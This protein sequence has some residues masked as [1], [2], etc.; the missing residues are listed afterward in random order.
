MALTM[1][2][3][4][5]T[6]VAVAILATAI[7]ARAAE[8]HFAGRTESIQ[9]ERACPGGM[10]VTLRVTPDGEVLGGAVSLIAMRDGEL[11]PESLVPVS[12]DGFRATLDRDGALHATFHVGRHA[13][14]VDLD[15]KLLNDRFVG[16]ISRANCRSRLVLERTPAS[17]R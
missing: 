12:S 10:R 4:R 3:A 6:V 5:F 1:R 13:E 15:G 8:G 14:L 17:P 9:G 16:V 7:S 11:A 2:F